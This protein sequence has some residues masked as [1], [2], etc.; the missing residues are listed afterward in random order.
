MPD[1]CLVNRYGPTARMGL[2]RDADEQD[3]A[4]PVLSISLGDPAVFRIGGRRRSD[5]TTSVLLEFGR[6]RRLR[7]RRPPRLPRHRPHPRRRLAPAPRGRP[8]QP[9]LPGGGL[10]PAADRVDPCR[11]RLRC[12]AGEG[13]AP[14][15]PRR[16]PRTDAARHCLARSVARRRMPEG[17]R[18]AAS[19]SARI[20]MRQPWLAR[21]RASPRQGW[22]VPICDGRSGRTPWPTP[23][24]SRSHGPLA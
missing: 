7:R 12:P 3:F 2:H 23:D 16:C 17:E 18:G 4:W 8:H 6:R 13:R 1:C 10:I 21:L 22:R 19:P 20:G 24:K 14:R 9:D 15:G 11:L 5:P